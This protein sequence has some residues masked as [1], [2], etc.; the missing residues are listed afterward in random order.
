[1]VM[2]S[3]Q[4]E[5]IDLL[6]NELAEIIGANYAPLGGADIHARHGLL[7][8]L[9]AQAEN[10]GNAA[11][12]VG[13]LG[14]ADCCDQLA[15]N[16]VDLAGDPSPLSGERLALVR[17]WAV[18]LLGYLQYFGRGTAEEAAVHRLLHFLGDSAWPVPMADSEVEQ[19]QQNFEQSSVAIEGDGYDYPEY[20]TP[21]MASLAIP[22]DVPAEL[23]QGL[24]MELPGQVDAFDRA[25]EQY[26]ITE[27][28]VQLRIAQRVAHTVKG[29]ANVVGVPGMAN[30]MHYIEDLLEY[31]DRLKAESKVHVVLQQSADCMFEA[32]D[33]L[34]GH[35]PPPNSLQET[36][37][38]VVAA[39]VQ[40][41]VSLP[42]DGTEEIDLES[43]A[44]MDGPSAA[45]LPFNPPGDMSRAQTDR[46]VHSLEDE[47]FEEVFTHHN[48]G[49][50]DGHETMPWTG[51]GEQTSGQ[52]YSRPEESIPLL[53]DIYH[54]PIRN[55][56]EPSALPSLSA[57]YESPLVAA[58]VVPGPGVP[59]TDGPV[60]AKE[61]DFAVTPTKVDAIQSTEAVVRLG[62][63]EAQAEELLRLSGEAQIGNAQLLTRIGAVASG[64]QA[65]ERYQAQMRQMA[66]Q[67]DQLVELQAGLQ[68]ATGML[69]HDEIDPLEL[70]RYNELNSFASQLH[71]LTTDAFEAIAHVSGDLKDLKNA[72]LNQ[73]QL[74]FE[75]QELLMRVRMLPVSLYTARFTRCVRQASRLIGK[76]AQLQV[77][78]EGVLVDTRVL[79]ALVD[80]IM[81]L[82]RNAVDHGLESTEAERTAAGKSSVGNITLTFQ[83]EGE[84]VVISCRDDGQGLDYHAIERSAR[85]HGLTDEPELDVAQLHA[86]ILSS[87]FSTRK[88]VTQTSGR[89]VGLDV[90]NAQVKQL[91]AVLSIDSDTG[92][93][94]CFTINAPMSILSAHTLVVQVGQHSFSVVS[95]SLEQVVYLEREK[96]VEQEKKQYYRL[97]DDEDLLPLFA[98]DEIAELAVDGTAKDYRALIVT[99]NQQ[100]TRC[101]VLVESVTAS[102]E[103]I[104]KPL[105]RY[106]YKVPGVIGATVLG[107]GRVSP[108]IDLHELPGLSMT[109]GAFVEWQQRFA[110]RLTD[111]QSI[112]QLERPMALVVD[113]SLSARRSLAQFVGDMGMEVY[114]AKDGF[115]AIQI[116]EQRTPNLILADLEM[117]RM[118][119]IEL[120]HYL[121]VNEA[122]RHIP[123]IMITSRATEKHKNMA[124]KV[125]INAY[126]NKPWTDDELLTSI[127]TQLEIVSS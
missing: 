33:F 16:F 29:A 59:E 11:R 18:P 68:S 111:L 113:D 52:A 76:P 19:A 58:Q 95:R 28:I 8:E 62:V 69:S 37:E 72:V 47:V 30:L 27:D 119:G 9:E 41:K 81:H 43:Q 101:G 53:D 82:L 121:R 108:V 20:I 5:L 38:D 31:P 42:N 7:E 123:V 83:R 100:G 98:L 3:E 74:G 13:L 116:V 127:Q 114:T 26:R 104:I 63:S 34:L 14:L 93:G 71:E 118:N 92:Q 103:Q 57:L 109:D 22:E 39:V 112:D 75:S 88:T 6:R 10:M 85:E 107:D 110:K 78:G 54:R 124:R 12:L 86:L 64:V 79:N 65:A 48:Q 1:M 105:S 36:I 90:V 89:G 120:T 99:R 44:Q 21:E 96:L 126:L 17:D 122:T 115:E 94:S 25:V 24:L 84:S 91:K 45:I 51:Q 102:E 106:A 2:S 46:V 50:D 60:F 61:P 56:S 77:K 67:L 15:R 97:A 66:S 49:V 55:P 125:G 35:G 87:G 117:P 32:C 73:R 40:T 70:E 80:P 4:Q 23:H